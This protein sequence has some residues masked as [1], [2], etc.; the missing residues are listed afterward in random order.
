VPDPRVASVVAGCASVEQNDAVH[1]P[2]TSSAELEARA[3]ALDAAHEGTDLR[4]RFELPPA[5][6]Y[7]DGN[8]LG[9]LP[10]GV[11]ER[12]AEVVRIEWG[13]DLVGS[14]N[15]HDWWDAPRR[16]GDRLAP[17]LGAA[18]GQVVVGDSTTVR[19]FQTLHA[20][21]RLR[22]DRR[23]LVTDPG[24]F[25]TD[26]Y[27]AD[28]VAQQVGWTVEH[29]TPDEAAATLARL[30]DEG[31]PAAAVAFSQ[32]DYRTGRLWDLPGVTAAAHRAGALAVWDLCHSAGAL[33]VG[34]DEH[35]VDLAVGCT[36]KFLNGGPGAP[37][38]GYVASRHVRDVVPVLPGWQG[39]ARPFAM[40]RTYE[41]VDDVARMRI[42]TP[43][44]IAL[45]ALEAALGAFDGVTIDAV[46]ARSL[47]LTGFLRD[48]LEASVTGVE[49]LTPHDPA[50]RG[51]QV[52]VRHPQAYGVVRAMAARGVVGDFRAPDVV[53]L[54]VAAPYLT[55]ADMLTT[56]RAFAAVLVADEHLAPEHAVRAAVT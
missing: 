52:S 55:H 44:M 53:R 22:P 31:R 19:L 14:W 9:A 35:A 46:R 49:V 54:G 6:V 21:A 10:R 37:A 32:V 47:S 40:E 41:P 43:P 51:S 38:Y 17:L 50:R 7:L 16:V 33:P 34:L 13:R 15:D 2:T 8:S 23:V 48:A 25:P 29:A 42:G 39:H 28:A 45:L 20:A 5:V 56:A 18:P 4:E 27:V 24:S 1:A 26:L 12:V 30:D 3:H 36:Y 11:A